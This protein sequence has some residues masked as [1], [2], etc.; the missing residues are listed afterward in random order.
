[1]AYEYC[2]GL[3]DC[4]RGKRGRC[5]CDPSLR[6]VMKETSRNPVVRAKVNARLRTN[7]DNRKESENYLLDRIL[8]EPNSGCWLWT[9][10]VDRKGYG[11]IKVHGRH[12]GAHRVAYRVFVGADPQ[13]LLICHR[14]DVPGCINPDHL[15][16]GTSTDNARD[17]GRKGRSGHGRLQASDVLEIRR[18]ALPPRDLAASFGVSRGTIH[19]IRRRHTWRTI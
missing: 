8:P 10:T 19:Q 3:P 5:P 14:C 4:R 18:S 1:M 15:F 7:W 11:R 12:V 16:I 17:M 2:A 13:D 6:S 9:G